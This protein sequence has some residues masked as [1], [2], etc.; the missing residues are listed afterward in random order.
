LTF[1]HYG[2]GSVWS[3]G[4]VCSHTSTSYLSKPSL[5]ICEHGNAQKLHFIKCMLW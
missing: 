3:W 4:T 2:V 1:F 5:H